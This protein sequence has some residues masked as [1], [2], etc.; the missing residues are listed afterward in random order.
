MQKQEITVAAAL[1]LCK[2]PAVHIA[3]ATDDGA[4]RDAYRATI[5]SKLNFAEFS[6]PPSRLYI[7]LAP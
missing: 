1:Q 4:R 5:G 2:R 3:R 7:V 6:S